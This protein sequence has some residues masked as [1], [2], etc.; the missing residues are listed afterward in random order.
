MFIFWV[1]F[2]SCSKLEKPK[3]SLFSTY[4]WEGVLRHSVLGITAPIRWGKGE[5]VSCAL[6]V[7]GVGIVMNYYDDP[8]RKKVQKNKNP[9]LTK[10]LS[11]IDPCGSWQGIV[12]ITGMYFL[13]EIFNNKKMKKA[14]L[15]S[16]ESVMISEAI[17]LLGKMVI[18]RARPYKGEGSKSFSLFT[19]HSENHSFP[20]GHTTVMFAI[21]TGL[22]E[23]W[24]NTYFSIILYT[25]ASLVGVARI[26]KDKHWMS[27]VI[28]GAT[29][30]VVVGKY[31]KR[32]REKEKL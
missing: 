20:S 10:L 24:R 22:S 14:S 28:T 26:Y 27:D 15:I 17:V 16:I 11:T 8:I 1:V 9:N 29:L 7:G 12:G 31:V 21:A 2:F 18:G 32:M 30:G 23:E 3:L 6:G 13:G 4:W 5:W 25:L 19:L